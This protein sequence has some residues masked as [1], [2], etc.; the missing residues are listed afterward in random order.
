[1]SNNSKPINSSSFQVYLGLLPQIVRYAL[2]GGSVA[3][4]DLVFFLVFA[5]WLGFP[6]LWVNGIGFCMGTAANYFWSIRWVFK[7]GTRFERR[8]EMTLVFL[9][10]VVG[11]LLAQLILFFFA[12]IVVLPLFLAKNIT[13]A[14][15][16]LGNY[17]ARKHFVFR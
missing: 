8:N 15:I 11:L 4:V 1:M 14:S 5:V 7:S 9:I 6:Y 3:A 16:F 17:L 10:S 13:V 12:S 2:V